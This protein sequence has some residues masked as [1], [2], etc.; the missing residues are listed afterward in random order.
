MKRESVGKSLFL[1]RLSQNV[2]TFVGQS[3][4]TVLGIPF[5]PSPF[6]FHQLITFSALRCLVTPSCSRHTRSSNAQ[7]AGAKRHKQS[8]LG[9]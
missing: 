3:R 5:S 4:D 2:V 1:L 8:Q 7:R 9:D 6:G